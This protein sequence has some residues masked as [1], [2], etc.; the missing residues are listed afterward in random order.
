M[1]NSP[2]HDPNYTPQFSGH[3]TFPMR[4]GWLKKAYDA[5]ASAQEKGLGYSIFNDEAAIARFGVG[6]NMVSAIRHWATQCGVIHP[7]TRGSAAS[8]APL[9]DTIFSSG[10]LDPYMEHPATLWLLHWGLASNA[11]LT[12]W[13]WVFS[14][15]P[16]SSFEREDIVKALLNLG[17][18]RGWSRIAQTTIKRDVEC[19]ARTYAAKQELQGQAREDTLESPLT[20]L[21]LIKPT[22]KKD[23]FRLVRSSKPTLGDGVFSYA[24][25]EFWKSFSDS[26]STISFEALAYHPG[27]PGK[28]FMLNEDDLADRL[29]RIEELTRGA[30]A[31]SETAGLKQIVR[32]VALSEI[33]TSEMLQ[34]DYFTHYKGA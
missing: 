32:K 4:Y 25:I 29:I 13:Y 14:H 34:R 18:E 2:L 31:W 6:K 24:L 7:G 11:A 16:N 27:S 28:V 19:F 10:G 15:Y 17:A 1:F 20:E 21:G 22:G 12:T 3:E 26:R 30:I 5:V 33:D 9:G 23:G 8:T